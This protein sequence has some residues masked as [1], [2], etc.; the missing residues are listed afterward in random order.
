M[1][2]FFIPFILLVLVAA[3]MSAPSI[4]EQAYDSRFAAGEDISIEFAG[5][6]YDLQEA[7]FE[8]ETVLLTYLEESGQKITIVS[9]GPGLSTEILVQNFL[10]QSLPFQVQE[11]ELSEHE[12]AGVL[13]EAVL[14]EPA[15]D[16][17]EYVLVRIWESGDEITSLQFVKNL[18]FERSLTDQIYYEQA[19]LSFR[20][21]WI[22]ELQSFQFRLV[23]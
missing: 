19:V 16:R 20:T 21:A 7:L 5:E 14:A 15:K 11:P 10:A 17:M 12:E 6:R 4:R 1:N 8:D 2:R 13:I 22:E 18:D 9:A 3:C 23:Q